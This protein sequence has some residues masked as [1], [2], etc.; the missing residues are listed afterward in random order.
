VATSVR[1]P[2]LL[3]EFPAGPALRRYYER[4][5]RYSGNPST[6][7]AIDASPFTAAG[8]PYLPFGRGRKLTV[9]DGEG[10]S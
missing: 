1:A 4:L 6:A 10:A 5:A 9:L 3:T 8:F 7:P 2:R